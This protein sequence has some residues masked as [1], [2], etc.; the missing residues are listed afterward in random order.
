MSDFEELV[1]DDN[2]LPV[3]IDIRTFLEKKLWRPE[4][5]FLVNCMD[6]VYKFAYKFADKWG[7]TLANPAIARGYVVREG[8]LEPPHLAAQDPKSCVST[9]STT[10]AYM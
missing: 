8:G 5:L 7:I 3:Q 9:S 2:Q 6:N 1:G 10:L 4:S